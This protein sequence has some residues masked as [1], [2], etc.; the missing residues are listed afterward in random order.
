[1]ADRFGI[2]KRPL[3]EMVRRV[4][5]FLSNLNKHKINKLTNDPDSYF[6]HNQFHSIP[7]FVV[8]LM[9]HLFVTLIS[10]QAQIVC[11]HRKKLETTFV[12]YPS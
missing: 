10:F 6:N 7:L 11:D 9:F 5:N 2:S 8:I 4:T 3:F 12:S 1:M